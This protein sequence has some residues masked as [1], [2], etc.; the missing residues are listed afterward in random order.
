MREVITIKIPTLTSDSAGGNYVTYTEETY[1]C[2]VVENSVIKQ[3]DTGQ[4]HYFRRYT[5]TLRNGGIVP[6]ITPEYWFTY[7]GKDLEIIEDKT[8]QERAFRVF[9]CSAKTN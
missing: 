8:T 1:R 7:R 3:L 6:D 5:V 2:S 9:E 4:V